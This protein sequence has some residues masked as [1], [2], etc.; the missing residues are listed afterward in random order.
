ME[1]GIQ[2]Q[3]YLEQFPD[4]PGYRK[5]SGFPGSGGCL[6]ASGRV[7]RK[8]AKAPLLEEYSESSTRQ[9]SRKVAKAQLEIADLDVL[10]D[11][12]CKKILDKFANHFIEDRMVDVP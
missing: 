11:K 1:I 10:A 12:V 9:A 6:K 7:S 5:L 8:V 2:S 3:Q 4:Y